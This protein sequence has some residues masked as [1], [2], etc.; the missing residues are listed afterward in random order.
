MASIPSVHASL[1]DAL[2]LAIW[3]GRGAWDGSAVDASELSAYLED[4][5]PRTVPLSPAAIDRILGDLRL[6]GLV[7][8]AS[9]LLS[10]A[11]GMELYRPY[12]L[13]EAGQAR[14]HE[15][16]AFEERFPPHGD[17]TPEFRRMHGL[18]SDEFHV[19]TRVMT[20]TACGQ[21][22]HDD[23]SYVV[24]KSTEGE[25]RYTHATCM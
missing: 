21:P 23:D 16:E 4:T 2:L 24:T 12:V 11:R 13:T 18:H 20:C 7:E 14:A 17:A 1:E 25:P 10:L 22:V 9:R 15:L 8:L 6:A 5:D 3:Q 19:D